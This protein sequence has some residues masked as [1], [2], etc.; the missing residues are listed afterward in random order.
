MPSKGKKAPAPAEN[1]AE[2]YYRLNKKAVEDLVSANEENSPPVSE[3]ELKK[4]RSRS[5]L[6]LADWLKALL[7]KFWFNGA[8]CFF[9]LWGL[10]MYLPSTLDLLFVTGIAM[11]IV[12]DLLVNNIFRFYAKTPG[13]ND[14]WMM[15]PKRRFVTFFLN[16]LYAFAVLFLVYTLYNLINAVIISFTGQTDSIPLGVGPIL[17]GLF[18]LGFDMLLIGMKRLFGRIL[19]DARKNLH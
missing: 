3:E 4:Y 16:I 5:P 7:I 9:F 14:R 19:S 12:T 15:F 17:F 6:R 11:G 18:Y 13:A 1:A 10:G 8:V 2:N